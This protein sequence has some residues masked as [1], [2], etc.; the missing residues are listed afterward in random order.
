ML[1]TMLGGRR[2]DAASGETE[3]VLDLSTGSRHA[4][5]ASSGATDVDRAVGAA[6]G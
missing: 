3:P 4:E 1:R 2:Q 5:A 6:L